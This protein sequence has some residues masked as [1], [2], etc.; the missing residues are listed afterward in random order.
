MA[1][2]INPP[3]SFGWDARRAKLIQAVAERP[4]APSLTPPEQMQ[5]FPVERFSA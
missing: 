4:Q 5:A 2:T 1:P 3:A